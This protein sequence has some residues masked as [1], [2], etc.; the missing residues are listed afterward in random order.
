VIYQ[1]VQLPLPL[2]RYGSETIDAPLRY[3]ALLLSGKS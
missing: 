3:P 1:V 2:R